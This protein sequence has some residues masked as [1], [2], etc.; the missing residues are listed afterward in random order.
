MQGTVRHEGTTSGALDLFPYHFKMP[1]KRLRSSRKSSCCMDITDI[2]VIAQRD[3][4]PYLYQMH[5]AE[6]RL[7][8]AVGET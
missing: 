5:V 3:E 2:E 7:L 4:V 6:K 8:L 1:D